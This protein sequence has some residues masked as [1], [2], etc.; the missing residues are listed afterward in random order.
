MTAKEYLTKIKYFDMYIRQGINQPEQPETRQI[1]KSSA[2]EQY[3]IINQIQQLDKLQ[4]VQILYKKYV[5][6][7]PLKRIARELS[8]SESHLKKLHRQALQEFTEKFLT[9]Q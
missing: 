1:I 4:H 9:A 6:Y 2:T 7:K 8:Y 5:E 3:K